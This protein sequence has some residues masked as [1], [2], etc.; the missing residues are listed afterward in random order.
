MSTWKEIVGPNTVAVG[1]CLG[2]LDGM[3]GGIVMGVGL[4]LSVQAL[5]EWRRERALRRGES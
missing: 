1:S 3:I 5:I 4:T 2:L